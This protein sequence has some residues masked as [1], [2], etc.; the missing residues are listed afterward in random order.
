MLAEDPRN[1]KKAREQRV[2]GFLIRAGAATD[3]AVAALHMLAR[4]IPY[5][6]TGPMPLEAPVALSVYQSRCAPRSK[7]Y[8]G[9]RRGR[10]SANTKPI[11]LLAAERTPPACGRSDFRRA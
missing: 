8:V 10:K 1:Q 7:R 4:A 9:S 6:T 5:D 2:R 11:P 3:H